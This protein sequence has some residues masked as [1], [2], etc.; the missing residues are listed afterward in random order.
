VIC[1]SL[2]LTLKNPVVLRVGKRCNATC[3]NIIS[4]KGQHLPWV[5][6]IK[7]LGVHVVR[8]RVFKCNISDAKRSFYRSA[9][10]IFGK[11]GRFA[12]ENVTLQLTQ[13][14]YV[15]ALLYGLDA[16]PLNKNDI[17]SLDFVV[18]QF[19]CEIIFTSDIN[20]VSECQQMF[21]FRLPSE[22]LVGLQRK[23]RFISSLHCV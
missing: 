18:N 22:E 19:F 4:L 12:P 3:A 9:N 14:K 16:C 13:S 6:E 15:P 23:G 17:T 5:S 1:P 11:I 2:L 20:I 21:N 10:E 7:Y 8:S